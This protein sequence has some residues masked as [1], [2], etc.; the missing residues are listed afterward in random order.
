MLLFDVNIWVYAHREDSP[1]HN[2]YRH[3]VESV[4]ENDNPFAVST[5]TLSGFVRIVTHPKI[6][7]PPSPIPTALRFCNQVINHQ[8]AVLVTPGN[9]HWE[10]FEKLCGNFEAKGNLVPDAFFAALAIESGCTWVSSDRD[11]S[12]FSELDWKHP[13][14]DF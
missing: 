6:F 11:F 10:I 9:R 4:M 14:F 1:N 7:N 5:L 12:R 8:D 13:L 3:F 2:Q